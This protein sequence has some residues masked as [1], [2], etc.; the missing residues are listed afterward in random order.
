MI[1]V[2]YG[3]QVLEAAYRAATAG[4]LLGVHRL[5]TAAMKDDDL[6]IRSLYV[7]GAVRAATDPAQLRGLLVSRTA[8]VRAEALQA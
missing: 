7:R 3:G 4:G 2:P 6:P 1:A 8:L 5:I